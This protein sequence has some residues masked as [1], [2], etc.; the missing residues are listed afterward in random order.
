MSITLLA[1][2]VRMRMTFTASSNSQA[3]VHCNE[4]DESNEY[5]NAQ[6]KILVRLYK[7]G[8]DLALRHFSQEDFGHQMEEDIAQQ[9]SD[10]EGDH[11]I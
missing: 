3:F 8:S 7:H 2:I 10:S 6:E 1:M 11:D 4:S 9:T 5:C